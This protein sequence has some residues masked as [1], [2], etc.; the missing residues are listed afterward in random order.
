MHSELTQLC[1]KLNLRGLNDT[2]GERHR[3]ALADDLSHVEFLI[4]LMQDELAKR[5]QKT[6]R[7]TPQTSAIATRQNPRIV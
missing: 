3:Q 7:H 6:P 5:Q 4:L 2:F 1:A